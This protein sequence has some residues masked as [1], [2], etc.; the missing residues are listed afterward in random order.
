MVTE[1]EQL[2]LDLFDVGM[3]LRAFR[4][5]RYQS[6]AFAV[7]ELIDNSVDAEATFVDVL[8]VERP[9]VVTTREVWRVSEIAVADNG[10]GMTGQTLVTALRFGGRGPDSN[11][12]GIRGKGCRHHRCPSAVASKFGVGKM[13]SRPPCIATLTWMRL[14]REKGKYRLTTTNQY[15][16]NGFVSWT[17]PFLVPIAA[18][19]FFGQTWTKLMRNAPIR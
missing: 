6:T 9:Q 18:L 2:K 4:D 19:W 12:P 10:Y 7:A 17:I 13:A 14:K 15:R 5:S 11:I 8:F 16:R 3:T 1:G